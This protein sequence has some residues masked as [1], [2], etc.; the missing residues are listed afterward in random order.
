MFRLNAARLTRFNAA[1]E[2]DLSHNFSDKLGLIASH[3]SL[4]GVKCCRIAAMGVLGSRSVSVPGVAV[5]A[6][7][8]AVLARDLLLLK[9]LG[10][11]TAGVDLGD[12]HGV[13]TR[14]ASYSS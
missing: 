7:S 1:C 13:M 10:V 8:V 11:S 3:H 4:V 2:A 14:V 5:L 12:M 9:K 6:D